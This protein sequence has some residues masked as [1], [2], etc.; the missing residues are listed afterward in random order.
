MD[1]QHTPQ[2]NLYGNLGADPEIKTLRPRSVEREVYD[3][4]ADGVVTKT[5][6][7]PA[8][9]IRTASLAVNA[10]DAQGEELTRW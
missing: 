2:I 7:Q 1:S 5:F 4:I 3:P 6:E 10:K 8:R 9:Q